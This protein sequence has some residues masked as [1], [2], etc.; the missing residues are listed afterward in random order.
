MD[1]QWTFDAQV[2]LWKADAAW[3]FVTVPQE[4][5]DEIEDVVVE[6]RGFGSLKVRATVGAT[7][8]S[9]SIFPSKEIGSFI[10][11]LKKSVRT[12]EDLAD[13]DTCSVM[14]VLAEVS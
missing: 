14:L 3:H 5:A 13:G 10:L 12:A 11:P 8:W 6:R 9:T 2:W 7:T 4:V 1:L